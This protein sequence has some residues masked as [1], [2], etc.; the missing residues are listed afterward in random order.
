M[1]CI[2]EDA[3]EHSSAIRDSIEKIA[4]LKDQALL[5]SFDFEDH[6]SSDSESLDRKETDTDKDSVEE[7][8]DQ[9]STK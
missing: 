5:A 3:L 1:A 9:E 7:R 8:S 2:D 4:K 6:T